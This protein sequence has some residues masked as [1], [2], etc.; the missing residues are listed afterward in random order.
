M[1]HFVALQLT[2]KQTTE[3]FPKHFL[4]E[5]C[6]V[7]TNTIFMCDALQNLFVFSIEIFQNAMI[8]KLVYVNLEDYF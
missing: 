3:Y 8:T 2:W 6:L 5:I 1:L 7:N 4:T